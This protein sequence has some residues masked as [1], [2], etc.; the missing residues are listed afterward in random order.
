MAA[1]IWG[2]MPGVQVKGWWVA[3]SQAW[4]TLVAMEDRDP[5]MNPVQATGM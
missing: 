1:P 3:G 4:R 5:K 2:A